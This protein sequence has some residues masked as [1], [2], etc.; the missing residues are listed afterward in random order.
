LAPL[1]QPSGRLLVSTGK[2]AADVYV[3]GRRMAVTPATLPALSAGQHVVEVR[4]GA[5]ASSRRVTIQAGHATY[6]EL[7]LGAA[8]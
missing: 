2:L 3:D 5:R 6:V 1:P 4:S 7:A 8:R